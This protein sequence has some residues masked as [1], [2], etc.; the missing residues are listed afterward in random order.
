MKKQQSIPLMMLVIMVIFAACQRNLDKDL[1]PNGENISANAKAQLSPSDTLNDGNVSIIE[2]TPELKT[3]KEN[4]EKLKKNRQGIARNLED[5]DY[6]L[7]DNMWAIREMPITI[8]TES[9]GNNP[10][11]RNNGKGKELT[12]GSSGSNFMIKVLSVSSGI[13]Y[14]L[15]PFNDQSAPVVVGYRNG[16][17]NDKLLMLRSNS[18]SSL[19]GASLDF[20]PA[21]GYFAIQSNDILGQGPGGWMDIFKYTAQVG[22]NNKTTMGKYT[23]STNQHFK[24][25]PDANFTLQSIRFI[26]D[27]SATL[28]P[29]SRYNVVRAFTNDSYTNKPYDFLFDEVVNES[30][31]FGEVRNIDIVVDVPQGRM[32]KAPEVTGGKLFLQPSEESPA[33]LRYLPNQYA[34]AQRTLRGM[35]PITTVP[36]ARTQITYSYSVYNVQAEYEVV[37]TYNNTDGIRQV[38]F[39]GKWTGQLYVDDLRDEHVYEITYMDSGRKVNGKINNVSRT[40]RIKLQ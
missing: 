33:T 10:Y 34:Q 20:I 4:F 29:A 26:N 18:N 12:F 22:S 5:Y 9:N 6:T 19:F 37:A 24:I 7:S 40:T 25:R 23:Q 21:K 2:E 1:L 16:N 28:T 8:R 14:L 36:R 38:K 15:Y 30:S 3:L 11:L 31:Y 17:P 13:P 27:Y 32:F 39:I 35:L